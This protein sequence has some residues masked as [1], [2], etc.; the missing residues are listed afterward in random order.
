MTDEPFYSPHRKGPPPR[1]PIPGDVLWT[2][3]KESGT[4]R[5]ELRNGSEVQILRDGEM[6]YTQ[7]YP[8]RARALEEADACRREFKGQGWA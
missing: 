6:F 7:R 3:T 4:L 1:E 2:L 5:A 8:S